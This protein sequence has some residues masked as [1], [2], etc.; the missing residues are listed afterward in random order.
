MALESMLFPVR[1]GV[2]SFECLLFASSLEELPMTPEEV[3]RTMDF[4][5]QSHANS[6][7]RMDRFEEDMKSREVDTD[8]RM[9]R[10]E[11]NTEKL[12]RQI[13]SLREACRDLLRISRRLLETTHDH[14]KRI[15]K[16]EAAGPS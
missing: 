7:V 16:I 3:E 8:A 5:L 9:A 11:S 1:A 14:S 10:L 12:Q 2:Y 4:I 13:D 6:V 15:T